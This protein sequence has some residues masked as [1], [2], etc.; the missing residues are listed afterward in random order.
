MSDFSLTLI[1]FKIVGQKERLALLDNNL[2][3]WIIEYLEEIHHS[4]KIVWLQI[5]KLRRHCDFDIFM[6]YNTKFTNILIIIF[7]YILII[8]Y[9]IYTYSDKNTL[10]LLCCINTCT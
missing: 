4:K 7:H 1:V 3:T 9:D 10:D 5:I 6:F 8:K 2:H